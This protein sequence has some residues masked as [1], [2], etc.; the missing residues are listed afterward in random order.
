[1]ILAA[2]ATFFK[3]NPQSLLMGQDDFLGKAEKAFGYAALGAIAG[4]VFSYNIEAYDIT[5]RALERGV[6]AR[7][8]EM[9]AE[10]TNVGFITKP[11]RVVAYYLHGEE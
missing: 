9:L 11:G 1:M 8:I 5:K 2:E 4:L 7:S 10:K 3:I 6:D